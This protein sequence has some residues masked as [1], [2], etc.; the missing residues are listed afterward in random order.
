MS[1]FMVGPSILLPNVLLLHHI[2]HQS[3][4]P[5]NLPFKNLVLVCLTKSWKHLAV[6]LCHLYFIAI[7]FL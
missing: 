1:F 5:E 4:L 2:K 6:L 3:F 7:K